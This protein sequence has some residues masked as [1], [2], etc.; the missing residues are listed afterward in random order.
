MT[1]KITL[2]LKISKTPDDISLERYFVL[3]TY[4]ADASALSFPNTTHIEETC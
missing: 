1:I 2:P 4:F 3:S